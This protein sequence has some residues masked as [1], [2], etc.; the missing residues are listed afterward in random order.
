V[1]YYHGNTGNDV[2]SRKYGLTGR[3]PAPAV[4]ININNNNNIK[5]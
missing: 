5:G 1:L 4:D 3:D 2:M